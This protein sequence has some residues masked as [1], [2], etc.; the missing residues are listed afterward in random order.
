ME[1]NLFHSSV[2][3]MFLEKFAASEPSLSGW[4]QSNFRHNED[5]EL[6]VFWSAP[7]DVVLDELSF[8]SP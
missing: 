2:Q 5:N 7:Y 6:T 4:R 3:P 8:W 1:I